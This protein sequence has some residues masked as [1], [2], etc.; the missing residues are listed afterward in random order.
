MKI[1]ARVGRR[2]EVLDR[3][4]S[5]RFLVVLVAVVGPADVSVFEYIKFADG[6]DQCGALPWG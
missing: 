1:V 4:D 2:T 5:T 6:R 3:H